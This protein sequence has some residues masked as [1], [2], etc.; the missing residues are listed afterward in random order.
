MIDQIIAERLIYLSEVICGRIRN[1]WALQVVQGVKTVDADVAIVTPGLVMSTILA[2]GDSA[3]IIEFGS[4]HLMETSPNIEGNPY[5]AEYM[6]SDRWNSAR[7]ADGNEF[8]GRAKGETVYRPDGTSYQSSGKA[9]GMRLEH[10]LGNLP[11]YQAQIPMHIIRNQIDFAMQLEIPK[12]LANATA[13]YVADQM[14]MTL[15]ANIYI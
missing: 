6:S 8:I 5:L 10:A 11:A 7:V 3:F 12:D 15:T 4:G 2:H 13:Q 14:V 1:E 9:E